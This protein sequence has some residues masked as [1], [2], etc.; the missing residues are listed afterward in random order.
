MADL[1]ASALDPRSVAIIGASDNIHKIGGRPIFYMGRHGYRGRIYPVNPA[2]EQVQGHR[3]YATLAD[4]PEVPE[5][6]LVV[7]GGGDRLIVK[8]SRPRLLPSS[9]NSSTAPEGLPGLLATV[10]RPS[11]T[12]LG[13]LR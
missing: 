7:V 10:S 6:A 12:V 5:L 3:S 4:V 8:P 1:L 13:T 2:R 11:R 9:R